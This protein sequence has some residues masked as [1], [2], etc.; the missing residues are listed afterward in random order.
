MAM[1]AINYEGLRKRET[2]EELIDFLLDKQP[3]IR[4][5]DRRATMS[6]SD[7]GV[8]VRSFPLNGSPDAGSSSGATSWP[9]LRDSPA[10]G[11]PCPD[12]GMPC[13]GFDPT[14][15]CGHLRPPSVHQRHAS[16]WLLQL[17]HIFHHISHLELF[18]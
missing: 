4:Y 1:Y 15:A 16:G 2:Y 10:F 13:P 12:R 14:M 11:L 3:N 18:R 5:P 6:A 7:G 9:F 17:G 8:L